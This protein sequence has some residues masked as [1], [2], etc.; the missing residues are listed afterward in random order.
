MTSSY[1]AM[2]AAMSTS[3]YLTLPVMG[4]DSGWISMEFFILLAMAMT[5]FGNWLLGRAFLVSKAKTFTELITQTSGREAGYLAIFALLSY[6]IIT[7]SILYVFAAQF[8]TSALKALDLRPSFLEDDRHC[9]M[10]I[11]FI[12][13]I[14]TFLASLTDKISALRYVTFFTVG[15][16]FTTVTIIAI[17]IPEVRDHYEK[18]KGKIH[19]PAFRV[20]YHMFGSY[21]LAFL[22]VI[23]QFAVVNILAEF[24]NPTTERV[25]SLTVGG[26]VLPCILYLLIA[27][28]GFLSCGDK[29]PDLILERVLP[30]SDIFIS[31]AKLCL[32][33][34]LLVG[35]IMRVHII[36]ST[37]SGF[38]ITLKK[39]RREIEHDNTPADG[40]I[41]LLAIKLLNE[42]EGSERDGE[43]NMTESKKVSNPAPVADGVEI[44]PVHHHHHHEEHLGKLQNLIIAFIPAFIGAFIMDFLLAYLQTVKP[45]FAPM[46]IIIFPSKA[47]LHLI[48]SGHI[49]ASRYLEQAI[50]IFY[51]GGS[52]FSYFALLVRSYFRII[53]K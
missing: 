44:K 6:V 46:F 7:M 39:R 8:A 19:Y 21:L 43:S 22:S 10:A 23:D 37:V 16:A 32:I 17:Q 42:I 2:I 5:A 49:E 41:E 29:C 15:I 40:M 24:K 4:R 53:A 26:V 28:A 27:N 47:Y 45:F 51:W 38:E 18:T 3:T 25:D 35:L 36:D 14:I 52:G 12:C 13:F 33:G 20:D 48:Q 11:I 31:L 50:K 30:G 34:S 1:L 9:E